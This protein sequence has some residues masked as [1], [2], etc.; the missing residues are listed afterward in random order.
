MKRMLTFMFVMGALATIAPRPAGAE[1]NVDIRVRIGDAPPPPR[2]VFASA[3]RLV[4]VPGTAVY[5]VSDDCD[6]D[7]FRYGG[8]WFVFH[9][10]WWYRS[11]RHGGPYRVVETRY[12]PRMVA[13]VPSKYWRHPH[14]GPPGLRK[15]SAVVVKGDKGSHIV[16]KNPKGKSDVVIKEKKGGHGP[17]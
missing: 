7:I 6:Y 17:H 14:G 9:D 5:Y 3:P 4:V 13:G 12:V 15:K 8:Y 16:V 2:I 10:G 11:G 1:T